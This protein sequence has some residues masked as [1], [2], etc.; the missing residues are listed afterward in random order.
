[1]FLAGPTLLWGAR[2]LAAGG[3]AIAASLA[4]LGAE[5][6]RFTPDE[7][8][9]AIGTETGSAGIPQAALLRWKT[10]RIASSSGANSSQSITSGEVITAGHREPAVPGLR[11]AF[12]AP[13]NAGGWNKSKLGSAPNPDPSSEATIRLIAHDPFRDPFGDRVAQA[14]REPALVPPA[15]RVQGAGQEAPDPL[16]DQ[17]VE[18]MPNAPR[19]TEP[20]ENTLPSPMDKL[21]PREDDMNPMPG[22][23]PEEVDRYNFRDCKKE[24]DDCQLFLE[25]LRGAPLSQIS[26][27]ILPHYKPDAKS[28]QEDEVERTTQL[29]QAPARDWRDRSGRLLA[30]G[31][32]ADLRSGRVII[33]DDMDQEVARLNVQDLGADEMCFL[34]GWWRLPSGC[35]ITDH[36]TAGRNWGPSTFTWTASAVCHKPLY[37]EQVQLERY[38]HTAGPFKQPIL[39]GAHFFATIG[40]L[41]YKMAINP[42][43]ECQYALGYYRPGSCAP[44]HIPPVPLSVRAAL[45]EAGAWVGGIYIIP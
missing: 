8:A 43:M 15:G 29:A 9:R 19:L 17:P 13:A 42:P 44:W 24:G 32:L 26:L 5:P 28:P 35:L 22:A 12:K 7:T 31:R 14:G 34:A 41:P 1:M 25:A 10:S 6:G 45:V 39:S 38:G 2:A 11:P 23:A 4:S 18:P 3:L 30:T 20:M 40:V 27:N 33:A 37:F 21:V 36:N 16:A